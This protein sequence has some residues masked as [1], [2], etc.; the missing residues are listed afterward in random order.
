MEY[1]VSVIKN[2]LGDHYQTGAATQIIAALFKSEN[3]R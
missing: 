3:M 1:A 2:L